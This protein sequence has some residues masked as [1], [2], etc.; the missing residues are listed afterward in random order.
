[1]VVDMS[2]LNPDID[3]ADNPDKEKKRPPV[4]WFSTI[5]YIIIILCVIAFWI[6]ACL[7]NRPTSVG[8]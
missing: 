3:Q 1:M 4:R 7:G 8:Q 2:N 6:G 5:I